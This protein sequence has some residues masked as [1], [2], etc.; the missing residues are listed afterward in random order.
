VAYLDLVFHDASE[1]HERAVCVTLNRTDTDPR[2]RN[3]DT[4]S[5]YLKEDVMKIC[6]PVKEGRWWRIRTNKEIR[7][8]PQGHDNVRVTKSLRLRRYVHGERM[9]KN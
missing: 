6:G 1:D 9:P 2:V 4:C 7:D 3:L 5:K 8:T